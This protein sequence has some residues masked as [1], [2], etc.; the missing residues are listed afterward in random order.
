MVYHTSSSDTTGTTWMDVTPDTVTASTLLSGETATDASGTQVTGNIATKT[1]SNMTVSGATITAPAGYYASNAS[2]SVSSGSATTPATTVTANPTISVNSS[3]GLITAT[4]SAT[5]S[6]TPTVSAG[7]VSAG[8]AG[9]ITVSGS[10][11]NQLTVQ[12]AQTIHPSTTD[13]TIASGKYLTGTQTVKAVT[14]TNLSA[15]NIAEGVTVKVGDSTDDDCVAS[16]TGT[17]Q[18]GTTPTGVKY[19][20][21]DIDREGPWDVSE[22]QYVSVDFS[23]VGDGKTRLWIEVDSSDLTFKA[24]VT[25]PTTASYRYTGRIDWGDGSAQTDYAY[26][27][28]DHTHTYSSPGRYVVEI[29]WTGGADLFCIDSAMQNVDKPKI[30]GLEIFFIGYPKNNAAAGLSN[31]KKM[32]YSSAQ[33][34]IQ[35]L[36]Y[37]SLVDIILPDTTTSVL[38]VNGC[39]SLTKLVI[40]ANVQTITDGA[41]GGNTSMLEY[42]FL[43]TTPPTLEGT[44]VFNNIPSGCII[45]VPYSADHSILQA[46]QTAENWSTHASKMQEVRRYGTHRNPMHGYGTH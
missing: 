26:G 16:V 5:Q 4:T 3:T 38:S 6:V 46:Y 44:T 22:Y 30:C 33:T 18:G 29:W 11:T 32:R 27:N 25:V 21:T 19:I 28:T 39:T 14:M 15:D 1:S 42:H 31:V 2:K 41:F 40:P 17:F 7:Y 12:A 9:T 10:N 34:K 8:T 20:W 36:N 24:P 13:Q 35:V 37:R 43:P 45:Y 23:P